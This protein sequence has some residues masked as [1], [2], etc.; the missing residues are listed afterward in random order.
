[1]HPFKF[2]GR[3]LAV[4]L[5]LAAL[6]VA[7][8][9]ADARNTPVEAANKEVVLGFYRALN[10]ADAAGTTS[11]RIQAIAEHYISP[12]YVQHSEMFANAPGPGSARDKLIRVFQ[13]MPPMKAALAPKTVAVMAQGDLV[14]LLTT[15]AMPDRVTG[16]PKQTYIFNMFRV[17]NGRLIEH[18]D[19]SPSPPGAGGPPVPGPGAP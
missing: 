4:G 18:W 13:S 7:G 16:Q 11:R 14:M 6:T 15:R 2:F 8:T 12:D 17:K 10:A 1:M 3:I 5:P 19:V 9:P